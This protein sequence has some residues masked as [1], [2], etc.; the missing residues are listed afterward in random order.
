MDLTVGSDLPRA[1]GLSSSSA[2]VVAAALALV[3]RAELDT[4]PEWRSEI[5]TTYD[6]AAY[7][8]A[9]ERGS[10]YGSLSGADAVGTLGGSEDHTAILACQPRVLSACRFIPMQ[11][12]GDAR[13][14]E[15]WEFVIASSGVVADKAG[16]ARDRFN[17][18][19]RAAAALVALWNTHARRPARTLV[20]IVAQVGAVAEL[21]ALIRRGGPVGFAPAA[22]IRRLAHFVAEDGRILDALAAFGDTDAPALQALARASQADAETLLQ[23]QTEETSALARLAREYGAIGACSF[24]A[25]FGGSVWA[26]APLPEIDEFAERWMAAYREQYPGLT[27]TWF[28]ARP[29]P[30][31]FQWSG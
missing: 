28:A 15:A 20:D 13:M 29:G 26:V 24:G 10:D 17:E 31:A 9:L 8:G 14:P 23:N 27:S 12:L 30:A 1:A 16:T 4:R 25:G 22:L 6:V 5:R 7:L 11:P 19:S 2:L 18:A 21:E 3:R